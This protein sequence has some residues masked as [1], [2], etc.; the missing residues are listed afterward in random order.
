MA[1]WKQPEAWDGV[2]QFD[3]LYRFTSAWCV[4][5]QI[6]SCA[7]SRHLSILRNLV[8]AVF[9]LA[10]TF[11]IQGAAALP[12][13]SNTTDRRLHVS[14]SFTGP[15]LPSR[16]PG[17]RAHGFG[18]ALCFTRRYSPLSF[19]NHQNGRLGGVDV[20]NSPYSCLPHANDFH[21]LGGVTCS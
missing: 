20:R 9:R 12:R 13:S 7:S 21:V 6:P 11:C 4:H 15:D 5:Q 17:V 14:C 2:L 3:C 18:R 16:T 10:G 19:A 8:V 1:T